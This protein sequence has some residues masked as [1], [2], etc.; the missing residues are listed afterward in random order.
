MKVDEAALQSTIV[1]AARL[2]GF[3]VY[4]TFD[5]RRSAGGFPD[6]VIAGA[7]ARRGTV[8]AWEL[9]GTGGSPSAEQ[10][11]WLEALRD[12]VTDARIVTPAELDDALRA[13][14]LGYWPS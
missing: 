7:G 5:S 12:V 13:L 1:E 8:F 10:L 4:H 3:L 2:R 6:L 11:A 9:K 14:E